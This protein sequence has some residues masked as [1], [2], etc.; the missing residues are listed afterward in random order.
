MKVNNEI[1]EKLSSRELEFKD[2]VS[3]G[4][5]EWIDADEEEDQYIASRP[6]ILPQLSPKSVYLFL[7]QDEMVE[8]W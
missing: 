2:L 4:F 1:L 3:R 8:Y 6:F 7:K 5:V